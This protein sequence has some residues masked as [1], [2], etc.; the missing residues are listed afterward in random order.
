MATTGLFLYVFFLTK[1]ILNASVSDKGW[2]YKYS[3]NQDAVLLFFTGL[4]LLLIFGICIIKT[5]KN[6]QGNR[7]TTFSLILISGAHTIYAIAKILIC[8]LDEWQDPTLYFVWMVISFVLVFIF[9]GLYIL[10][11][12][13][14]A[15][16]EKTESAI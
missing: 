2:A 3:S 1:Y 12:Q 13:F 15:K 4:L 11:R 16:E 14:L 9:I 5:I 6:K 8:Y 7:L 10:V